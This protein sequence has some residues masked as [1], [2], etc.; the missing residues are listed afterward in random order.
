LPLCLAERRA[1]LIDIDGV[2]GDTFEQT[3][4]DGRL[5]N[6]QRILGSAMW[7]DNAASVFPTVTMAGQ[8]SLFT[9]VPPATHGVIGNQWFDRAA[10]RMVDYLTVTGVACVYGFTLLTALNA[11]AAWPTGTCSRRRST[12]PPPRPASRAW[13]SSTSTGKAPPTPCCRACSTRFLSSRTNPSTTKPST[14]A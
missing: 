10:G 14:A 13:W 3:Y 6:F 8:A 5:P 4:R 1:V 2:R 11:A 7:F 9:G 12:K